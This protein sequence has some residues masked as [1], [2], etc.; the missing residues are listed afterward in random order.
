[1]A[2][3][4]LYLAPLALLLP[5]TGAGKEE[6]LAELLPDLPRSEADKRE[7]LRER[8]ESF[9]TVVSV[10]A[11]HQIRIER[12]VIIRIAPHNA[13]RRSL[14]AEGRRN[15]RTTRVVARDAGDCLAL[16]SIAAVRST[17]DNKL[18]LY[19]RDRRVMRAS[20]E[21]KCSAQDYYSGFYVEPHVDG[22]ICVNRDRLQSRTGAKCQV[23]DIKQLVV[24]DT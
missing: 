6:D 18:M 3:F 12:R 14:A 24:V 13:A 9:D 22:R 20:L 2:N 15:A 5:G 23:D 11:Q 10:P 16:K 19:L 7:G 1:M 8:F 17:S 4:L 21:R